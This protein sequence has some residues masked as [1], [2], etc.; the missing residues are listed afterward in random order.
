MFKLQAAQN[1]QSQQ[2]TPP[3]SYCA[4]DDQQNV[5]TS[6]SSQVPVSVSQSSQPL[7]SQPATVRDA[8]GSPP[9]TVTVTTSPPTP[10]T[11]VAARGTTLDQRTSQFP[12]SFQSLDNIDLAIFGSVAGLAADNGRGSQ[13]PAV[14]PSQS[15]ADKG[16]SVLDAAALFNG[17]RRPARLVTPRFR[18]LNQRGQMF[19]PTALLRVDEA[20]VT[21]TER[22]RGGV[23]TTAVRKNT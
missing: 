2:R 1:T 21:M 18:P 14:T 5:N 9:T 10:S 12:Q 7:Q 3:P 16:G 6:S 19:D 4:G 23:F 22:S 13:A 11:A 20:S 17:T 15:A 8:S